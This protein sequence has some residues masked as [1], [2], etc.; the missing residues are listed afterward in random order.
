[1]EVATMSR[2]DINEKILM[3]SAEFESMTNKK[4]RYI[5]LGF[6]EWKDFAAYLNMTHGVELRIDNN[7]IVGGLEIL[8]V[9]KPSHLG[10]GA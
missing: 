7:R 1:M 10:V 5:Y 2:F 3:A 9:P 8:Y 4:P 6:E